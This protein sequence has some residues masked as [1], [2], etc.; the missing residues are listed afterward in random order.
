MTYDVN[1]FWPPILSAEA[2]GI[3]RRADGG[4]MTAA[5]RTTAGSPTPPPWARRPANLANAVTAEL[6]ERIVSGVHPSG[7]SLPPEPALCETFSV[8]R[9]VVRE[10]VKMLQQKGLVQVRQGSGTTVTPPLMWNMLDQHVLA[11]SI[12]EDDGLAVLDDL[13]V[14]RRLLES[15]MAHVAA[16]V[17]TD[18]VVAGLCEIVDRMDRLVDDHLA[19]ADQDRAFHDLI[20]RTSG[21][22]IAR[23][24]VRA[25]ESQVINTA[26]YMGQPQRNLCVASNQGHRRI[27][28]RIAAHDHQGAAEAMFTHITEAWLVRRAGPANPVRLD[29]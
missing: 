22:R 20:M 6:V 24:V 16:R 15:D 10:A 7:S 21:N 26:R 28:E 13:V 12:A 4:N 14:T 19:Y 29:R 17:A 2:A 23:A 18:D 1:P 8:S 11:A 3:P 5:E 27:Y 25:L 9:T